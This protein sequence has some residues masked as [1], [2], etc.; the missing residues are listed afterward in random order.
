MVEG[1]PLDYLV[2][3]LV[4]PYVTSLASGLGR[5]KGAK[6]RLVEPLF[7]TQG[8]RLFKKYIHMFKLK[9]RKGVDTAQKSLTGKYPYLP[10]TVL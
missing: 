5:T 8:Y 9:M 2:W 7:P 6:A 10:P 1:E 4:H 3:F